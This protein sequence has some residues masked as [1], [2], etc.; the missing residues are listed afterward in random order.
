LDG[1][2]EGVV[3]SNLKDGKR[4]RRFFKPEGRINEGVVFSNLKDG[5][6]RSSPKKLERWDT[7]IYSSE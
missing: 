2:N 7:R 1:K 4:G 3:F 5:K 6:K